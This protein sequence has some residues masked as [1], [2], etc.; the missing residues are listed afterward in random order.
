MQDQWAEASEARAAYADK[1]LQIRNL[2]DRIK[3]MEEGQDRYVYRLSPNGK[4]EKAETF[5]R[6]TRPSCPEGEVTEWSD[7]DVI[8]YL[9]RVEIHPDYVKITFKA[10]ITTEIPR[11]K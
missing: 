4:C 9:E 2:Q 11:A 8:R 6:L 3:V 10:G 7:D 1:A 5:Y